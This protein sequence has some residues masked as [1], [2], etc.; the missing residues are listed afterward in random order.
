MDK[1]IDD[2]IKEKISAI[3]FILTGIVVGSFSYFYESIYISALSFILMAIGVFFV[4]KTMEGK[5]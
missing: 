1:R 3:I 5:L 4:F 2:Y